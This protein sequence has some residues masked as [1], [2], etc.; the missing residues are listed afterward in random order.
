LPQKTAKLEVR[1][2]SLLNC[3]I[4]ILDHLL[5][6]GMIQWIK[7]NDLISDLQF[8]FMAGKSSVYQL[9]GLMNDFERKKGKAIFL[10]SIDLK[11]AYDRVD[12]VTLYKRLKDNGL[13]SECL[14]YVFNLLFRP[15]IKVSS[16][17][18]I[19]SFWIPPRIAVPQGQPLSIDPLELVHQCKVEGAQLEEQMYLCLRGCQNNLHTDTP[20]GVLAKAKG[21]LIIFFQP[22]QGPE[23]SGVP[24]KTLTGFCEPWLIGTENLT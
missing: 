12:N 5:L 20:Q 2:I 7:E 24:V 17:N 8:G 13:L 15:T 14:S 4:K 11:G 18:G 19:S 23:I 16:W 9:C 21:A 22:F 6:L 3:T 10:L 1:T